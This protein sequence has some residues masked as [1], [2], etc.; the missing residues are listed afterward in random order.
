MTITGMKNAHA[1]VIGIA[2]YLHLR[3][4]PLT[5][6][7]DAQ[8]IYDLLM[9]ACYCGYLVENMQLL[10]DE[11]ATQ[12][13]IRQALA[14]LRQRSDSDSTVLIYLSS[15]GGRIESGPYTGEYLLPVDAVYTS[16]ESLARTAI[17]GDELTK[18]LQAIP[19]RKIVVAFDCCHS[20][21]LGQPKETAVP[22][23][24]ALPES[25]Y[26]ALKEGQGR[27]ILASS[28]SSEYSYVMPGDENSLFTK[29][30]LSGLKG[31]APGPGGVIRI[32]DLFHYLQTK[33][34]SD[35]PNQHP[36]FKAEIEEN[37]PVALYMGGKVPSPSPPPLPADEFVYDVFLSYRHQEPDKSW[38]RRTLLP[39]LEAEGLQ[40]CV[41]YR[42]FRLG[43]PLV[44][45]M[46]RAV[47]QSRYTL[48]VLSPVYSTS[49]FADLEN[50]LAEHL[51]LEKGQRRLLTVM[52]Q[53]CT[54]RL[55]IR[56]RM[57]L[58]MTDDAEFEINLARL[59]YE[60]RQS[61]DT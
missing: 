13:A 57:W 58:D 44:L 10:L 53:K 38:V 9:N 41:D 36:I 33:V 17:S 27:V 14:G 50:I 40:A 30:L 22:E 46:A 11:Q 15:H 28:R 6:L 20:G 37:F 26:D 18:A 23:V 39:R 59:V 32:F 52:H 54:P 7:K 1:L 61:P 5:V 24:Q 2:N 43:A 56:S 42:D 16:T 3:R 12:A 55:G 35:Q 31:G 49:N 25:Y 48:A 51:G 4:L 60:L 21:G 34:T 8:D 19:A 47:E 45:E 29:H